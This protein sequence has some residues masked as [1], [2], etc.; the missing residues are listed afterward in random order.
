MVGPRRPATDYQGMADARIELFKTF[1]IAAAGEPRWTRHPANA[2][3]DREPP[4]FIL[5]LGA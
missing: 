1:L 4:G 5:K 2:T 3:E